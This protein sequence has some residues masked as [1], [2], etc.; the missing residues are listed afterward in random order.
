MNVG[1]MNENHPRKCIVQMSKLRLREREHP[2]RVSSLQAPRRPARFPSP[3][4][5]LRALPC[6]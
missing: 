6:L 2:A 4:P 5:M 3:H 1:R